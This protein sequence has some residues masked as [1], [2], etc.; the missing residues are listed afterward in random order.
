MNKKRIMIVDDHPLLRQGLRQLI[1]Q[2]PDLKVCCEADGPQEA[3]R[4]IQAGPP[5]VLIMDISMSDQGVSGLDLIRQV[6]TEVP[7]TAIL[8]FSIHE[9]TVFAERAIRA[10]ALGFLMKQTPSD[11]VIGAI[12]RVAKGELVLS[13]ALTQTI[14]RRYLSEGDKSGAKG[15]GKLSTREYEV[16][17]LAGEG[18][19]PQ[20]ISER[21]GISAK[22]VETHRFNIRKKLHLSSASELIQFAIRHV[23]GREPML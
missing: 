1:D 14:L 12:R 22:T 6:R 11:L 5:E 17:R 18:M 20:Q 16:L 10:G 15:V 7:E 8:V 2:E 13:G 23:H 4:L 19:Q 9:E 3:L 21:L